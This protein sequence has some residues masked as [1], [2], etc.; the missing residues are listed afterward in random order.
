M[1][2]SIVLKL[3]EAMN[4]SLNV[5]SAVGRGSEFTVTLP[6]PRL[7]QSLEEEGGA[8]C[9]GEQALPKGVKIMVVDDCSTNLQVASAMLGSCAAKVSTAHNS[10]EAIELARA[11]T[12]DLILMD[13]RMPGRDG[14]QVFSDIRKV[15]G[16]QGK[17]VPPVIAMTANIMAHQVKAYSE[18]GFAATVA[19]PL[20]QEVLVQALAG[21]LSGQTDSRVIIDSWVS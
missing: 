18:A 11:Q 21:V 13:I 16:E 1:G 14:I 7:L 20:R 9:Q 15:L 2:L 12:F 8:R 5:K 6:F 4:G 19:K 3:V 10:Q 17:P